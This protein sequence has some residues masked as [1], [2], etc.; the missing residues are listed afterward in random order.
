MMNRKNIG[1]A[2]P[3]FFLFIIEY[4]LDIEDEN[5]PSIQ[6]AYKVAKLI[7]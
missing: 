7:E 6:T 2:F 3:M 4:G 1:N 5:I